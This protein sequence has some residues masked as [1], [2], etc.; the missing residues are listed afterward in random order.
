MV[1]IATKDDLQTALEMQTL[2]ISVRVGVMLAAGLSLMTALIS[3]LI[4]FH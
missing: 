1:D 2:R 4:K 3:A